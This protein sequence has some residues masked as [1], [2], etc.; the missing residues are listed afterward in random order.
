LAATPAFFCAALYLAGLAVAA[1]W[2]IATRM[3]P[4]IVVAAIAASACLL[5]FL[6]APAALPGHLAYAL[7]VL[8]GGALLFALRL[9][10]AGDAKLL[11]ASAILIGAKGLTLLIAATALA[12]G[13]L[14]ILY[15]AAKRLPW[16]FK[17]AL[18]GLPYGVA[19]ACGAAVAFL[20]TDSF[21]RL[22]Q[23]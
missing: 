23:G 15:V 7:A 6:T 5:L 21:A 4:N 1:S 10:G 12:G 22:S 8:G 16:R 19:I 17:P 20:G 3:I 9:W 18:P 13:V 11:A 14:A 2:D